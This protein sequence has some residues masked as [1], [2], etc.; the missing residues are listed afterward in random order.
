[1]TTTD[2]LPGEPRTR[3]PWPRE[4]PE[5]LGKWPR[6]SGRQQPLVEVWHEGDESD[7][8]KC[9]KFGIRIGL[10]CMPW[11]WMIV[12][13]ILSLLPANEWG[14]RL[15]TH[16]NV[17]IECTRQQGKTLI[18]ILIILWKL[19]KCRRRVVYTAQQW[20]TVED[21]F[22]RVVAVIER[23]PSLQRRLAKPPSKKDNRGVIM[24]KPIPG[25]KHVVKADF[26]PRTQHFAR[27]FTEVDDLILDEA[28]DLVPKETANLTGAQAASDNPQTILASTPPV[29]D[30]HPNC[31]RF[32]GFVRTI[33]AGGAA[34]L[35]G[36]LYRAPKTLNRTDPAAYPLA[37]PSYGVVGN[38]REME[39]Y[40]QGA[41][42]SADLALFDA[43]WLGWGKYPPPESVIISEIPAELWTTMRAE[44]PPTFVGSPG[45]GLHRD[46]GSGVWILTAAWGTDQGVAHLEIGYMQA[47]TSTQVV[48]AVV[49]LVTAWD[50]LAVAMRARG[51]AAAIEAELIKAGVEPVMVNSAVWSQWC[52][53][54]LNA[55]TSSKLSHSGQQTLDGAAGAA[56]KKKLPAGGFVWDEEA[57]VSSAPGLVS[58]TLAHGALLAHPQPPVSTGLPLTDCGD[59]PDHGVESAVNDEFDAL[60]AV[61]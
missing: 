48:T 33:I 34:G 29:I 38:D 54:F 3:R 22:D 41:K 61:F 16:R 51:D 5:F 32:S 1:M 21:V 53:G 50:P 23:V 57:A 55:A 8:D 7:G 9:T 18:L 12:R 56:V 44:H 58:A 36:V 13:A 37:Q 11:E 43:D 40:L 27:G 25:D 47:A 20:A 10:R 15:Y 46:S 19:F 6:L 28:Y 14:L 24:L 60:T 42:T 35:Y 30:E 17:V 45:I 26:G 52:G 31:H 4:W 39:A 59:V 2:E 49:E